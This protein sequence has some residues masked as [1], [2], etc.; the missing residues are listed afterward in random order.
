MENAGKSPMPPKK[1]GVR[2]KKAA[3]GA[4]ATLSLAESVRLMLSQAKA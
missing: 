1:A 2:L 4:G 3:I